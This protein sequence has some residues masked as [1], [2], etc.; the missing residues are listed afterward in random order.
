MAITIKCNVDKLPKPILP[1]TISYEVPYKPKKL[2]EINKEHEKPKKVRGF[3]TPERNQ[4]L[5]DMYSVG[6]GYKEIGEKFGRTPEAIRMQL[7]A[8]GAKVSKRHCGTKYT[9][10]QDAVIVA[11]MKDGKSWREIADQLGRTADSVRKH[12]RGY[13]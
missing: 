3:W 8:I 10:A 12:A 6:I 9:K 11:M 2:Y 1:P 5:I 7:Y 4:Q 13:L